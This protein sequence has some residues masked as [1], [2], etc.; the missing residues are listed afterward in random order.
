MNK[1]Q[2][3]FSGLG[4]H[5]YSFDNMTYQNEKQ[6]SVANTETIF[7]YNDFFL[8]SKTSKFLPLWFHTTEKAVLLKKPELHSACFNLRF[9]WIFT[10]LLTQVWLTWPLC[11]WLTPTDFH[12]P[13]STFARGSLTPSYLLYHHCRI[14]IFILGVAVGEFTLPFIRGRVFLCGILPLF[15]LSLSRSRTYFTA[16]QKS[17]E[18]CARRG[19]S[20]SRPLQCFVRNGGHG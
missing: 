7:C 1:T 3:W 15:S 12:F 8:S 6:A 17:G 11:P 20:F 4:M 9:R 13:I 10:Q 5:Y 18:G 2:W 16:G 19:Q 14:S